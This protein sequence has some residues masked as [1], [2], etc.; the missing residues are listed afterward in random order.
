MN[1][2]KP[3]SRIKEQD[4]LSYKESTIKRLAQ[5]TLEFNNSTTQ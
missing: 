2:S 1:T 4:C 3:K 5:Q